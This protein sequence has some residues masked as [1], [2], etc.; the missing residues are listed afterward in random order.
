M[1]QQ[2]AP[3]NLKITGSANGL[4]QALGKAQRDV[5]AFKANINAKMAAVSESSG[6]GGLLGLGALRIG[7]IAAIGAAFA[8][9]AAYAT[10][11]AA[12]NQDLELTF[13]ALTGSADKARETIASLNQFAA[14]TP[15]KAPEVVSAAKSLLTYG[16]SAEEVEKQLK[17]IGNV[18]AVSGT[19]FDE[20]AMLVGRARATNLVFTEDLNQ[21]S[22]RAIPVIDQLSKRFGVTGAEVRKLASE[23]K[24]NFGDLQAVLEALGGEGGKFADAMADRAGTLS[25]QLSTLYDNFEAIAKNVGSIF[26]PA[27]TAC[28]KALNSVLEIVKDLSEQLAKNLGQFFGLFIEETVKKINQL[29]AFATDAYNLIAEKSG[30]FGK[31]EAPKINFKPLVDEATTAFKEIEKRSIEASNTISN[32]FDNWKSKADS[33]RDS[34]ATPAEEYAKRIEELSQ[35]VMQGGLEMEFFARGV[36]RAQEALQSATSGMGSRRPKAILQGSA[37][38]LALNYWPKDPIGQQKQGIQAEVDKLNNRMKKE[39]S[40]AGK[41]DDSKLAEEANQLLTACKDELTKIKEALNNKPNA[42]VANF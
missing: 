7:P 41:G 3:L 5:D 13:K 2:L 37:E 32:G 23:G 24:I 15:F 10:K 31:I 12:G 22:D 21:F 8:G 4:S 20:L 17:V 19:K 34:L 16:F 30:L 26:V 36:Q 39:D 40:K 38:D 33:I 25:G 14:K 1:A 29:L 27:L 28:A 42:K 6:G 9:A 11:L 35:A 18:A